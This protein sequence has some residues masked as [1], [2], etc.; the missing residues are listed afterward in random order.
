VLVAASTRCYAELSFEDACQKLLDLE[1]SSIE[2]TLHENS[3]Q[4][5]PSEVAANIE[6]A[7]ARCNTPQR[8][9]VVAYDV[10]IDQ[11]PHY[12]DHFSA[13]C[14]L[15]KACKVVTISTSSALLGTP[16]NE[17]VERLRKLVA[18]ATMEG[19][20]VAMK[21]QIG[22]L[23]EDPDTVTVLCDNVDGLGITLDPSHYIVG[24]HSAKGYDKILKYV[25]HVLLRDTSKTDIQVRIGQGELEYNRLVTQLAHE[26]YKRALCVDM[27]PLEGVDHMVELRKMRLLLESLL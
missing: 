15:A 6:A 11:G 5:K 19:V 8:L 13:C 26:G 3:N 9:D 23:S 10:E 7:A 18:I 14:K 24:P 25:Y 27:L 4:V 12:Y 22:R 17:E 20:R 2:I 21:T 1:Y 16:F